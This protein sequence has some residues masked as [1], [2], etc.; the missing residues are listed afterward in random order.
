M[1]L[2]IDV[3]RLQE[4]PRSNS[5]PPENIESNPQLEAVR[6]PS[7]ETDWRIKYGFMNE[8][9]KLFHKYPSSNKPRLPHISDETNW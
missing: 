4:K 8:I 2:S 6:S 5:V 7:E 9:D 3:S 1:N